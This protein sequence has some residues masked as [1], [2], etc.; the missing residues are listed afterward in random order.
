[1]TMHRAQGHGGYYNENSPDAMSGLTFL[2]DPA[3]DAAIAAAA[4]AA[5]DQVAAQAAPPASSGNGP[6]PAEDHTV[7]NVAI[8]GGVLLAGYLLYRQFRRK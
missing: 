2:G 5:G 6:D 3:L 7:R 1:M 4:A 8:G